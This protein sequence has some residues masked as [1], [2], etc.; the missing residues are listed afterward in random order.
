MALLL[1]SGAASAEQ[2]SG[3][4][5]VLLTLTN[6]CVI[7]SVGGTDGASGL[8]FGTINFGSLPVHFSR[9]DAALIGSVGS[10]ISV[11]CSNGNDSPKLTFDSGL[12]ANLGIRQMTNGLT[13]LAYRL[14][15][16]AI[17]GT[18]IT[19]S[20]GG[21][22]ISLGVGGISQTVKIFARAENDAAGTGYLTAGLYSDTIGVTLDF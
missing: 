16:D 6:G 14:Y 4:I 7:N 21:N 15:K 20:G 3:R 5:N 1:A 2:V 9:V 22:S 8:E 13:S 12:H 19:T 18:E 10:G 11:Q 17:N